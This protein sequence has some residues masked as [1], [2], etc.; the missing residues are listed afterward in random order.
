MSEFSDVITMPVDR[1]RLASGLGHS[2]VW[3]LIGTGELET[4]CI[5]KRRLVVVASY[6]RL[7]AKKLAEPREDARKNDRVPA[8]GEKRGPGR[9]RKVP[10]F[11][12][13]EA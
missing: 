5:G 11:V 10:A 8:M 12:Q 4:V 7:I 1:F 13:A 9:P 6:H 3:E 2:K